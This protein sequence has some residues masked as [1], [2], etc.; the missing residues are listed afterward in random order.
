MATI[1][2]PREFQSECLAP[3]SRPRWFSAFTPG[4]D[5]LSAAAGWLYVGGTGN[6]VLT[7]I[8]GASV[9]LNSLAAGQWHRVAFTN[10]SAAGGA[11]GVVVGW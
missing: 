10:V 5:T 11:T 6:V 3:D 7:T 2:P 1:T 8:D 9:T 4:T